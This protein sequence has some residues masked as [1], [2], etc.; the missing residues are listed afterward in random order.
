M[1]HCSA[2]KAVTAKD[3]PWLEMGSE[4]G[5]SGSSENKGAKVKSWVQ[6]GG[7]CSVPDS[8]PD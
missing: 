3:Q 1:V 4:E 5:V 7:L 8:S 2:G 6:A